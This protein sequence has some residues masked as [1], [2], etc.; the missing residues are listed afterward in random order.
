VDLVL[1]EQN[2]GEGW[3]DEV[4]NNTLVGVQEQVG[5]CRGLLRAA[6]G[7]RGL[8]GAAGDALE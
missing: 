3:K 4:F 1:M 7:C 8:P 6:R 5:G 2:I